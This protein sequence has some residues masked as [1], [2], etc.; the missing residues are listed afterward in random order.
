MN[1]IV[2]V[3]DTVNDYTLTPAEE[4]RIREDSKQLA[5]LL[6]QELDR[7]H[8]G[9]LTIDEFTILAKFFLAKQA[10]ITDLDIDQV[11]Q[12][13]TSAKIRVAMQQMGLTQLE[14]A[15]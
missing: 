1:A 9:V 14:G 3:W 8:N 2:V 7:D 11:G 15:K 12:V 6:L 4:D 5:T 13:P 10:G